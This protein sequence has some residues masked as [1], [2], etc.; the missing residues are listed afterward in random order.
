VIVKVFVVVSLLALLV[1][2]PDRSRPPRIPIGRT[3]R[4]SP[5]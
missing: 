3:N 1:A 2:V 5:G 4:A